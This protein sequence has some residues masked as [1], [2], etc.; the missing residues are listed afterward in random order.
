MLGSLEYFSYISTVIM[1]D[2]RDI[3]K[4]F[5][6][7]VLGVG[8]L[9]LLCGYVLPALIWGFF[10]V[11]LQMMLFP[12]TSLIVLFNLM[13]WNCVYIMYTERKNG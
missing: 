11:L 2:M 12:L 4:K 10:W 7:G 1:I 6:I 5:G 9:I 8:I 3:I 13:M